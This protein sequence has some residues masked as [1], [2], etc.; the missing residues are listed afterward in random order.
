MKSLFDLPGLALLGMG[1]IIGL[2]WF[3]I[4]IAIRATHI[5]AMDPLLPYLLTPVWLLC[6]CLVAAGT[7][8][9]LEFVANRILRLLV[10]SL[11]VLLQC[12]LY[13]LLLPL[14]IHVHLW[15]GGHL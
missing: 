8:D 3:T 13:W 15:S 5:H 9:V 11:A 14:G 12:F 1:W 10:T 4:V 6:F 7:H 2:G